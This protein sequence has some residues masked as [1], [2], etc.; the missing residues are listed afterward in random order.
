M[1]GK[2]NVNALI[3][4]DPWRSTLEVRLETGDYDAGSEVDASVDFL[5]VAA[6]STSMVDLE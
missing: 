6:K 1:H 4:G 5:A 3:S 2:K